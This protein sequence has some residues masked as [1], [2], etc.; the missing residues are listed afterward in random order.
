MTRKETNSY[1]HILKYTGVFGGV[2]GLSILMGLLR[3][4][5]VAV[6]LGPGGMG[7]VSLFNTVVNFVSQASTF[8]ISFS[9]VRHVS[10]LYDRG[11]TAALEHYVGVIRSWTLLVALFGV[12]LCIV[13]GPFLSDSTFAWG[14]HTLHFILLS[15]AVGMLA[16][17]GGE[18]AILKGVRRLRQLAL[19]QL[20]SIVATL[21]ISVPVFY[22]FC[23]AG[24]V[25][26]IVLTTLATMLVTLHFS[27]RLFPLKAV[28][29]RLLG[30]GM[31][32]VRLGVA[33]TAAGIMGS[34]AELLV[35]SFLNVRGDLDVV[36]LYNSAYMLCVTYAGMVFSAMETDYFPRLSAANHDPM[37]RN[38]IVNRQIEVSLLIVSPM[39]SALIVALP[40]VVPLL[41]SARFAPI[42]PM[43]QVMV[44]A[45]YLRAVTL[46]VS[47]IMLATGESKY[48]LL[49]EAFYDI[50]LVMLVTVLFNWMGL[51]GTGVA[52]L[53]LYV[54]EAAVLLAFAHAH[55]GTSLTPQ[56][57]RCV[58]LQLPL[59]LLAYLCTLTLS[60]LVYW[61]AGLAV[62]LASTGVSAAILRSKTSLWD[63]LKQKN[64]H[65]G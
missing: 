34:G 6:L 49:M 21:A 1:T 61:M 44:I 37:E 20:A 15:P 54:L 31:G 8:G 59:G 27:L 16:V 30:D 32:M 33:Y 7:L 45:M 47:Y 48:Y 39:L 10:E 50:L 62:V 2:Q 17:T 65:H 35:R 56:V 46:P 38:R 18:T 22:F 9:A 3:N 41:F 26:V 14:D 5:I 58:A 40:V 60:G 63:I 43:G 25:P 53:A 57:L 4:K 55:Y 11:D 12:L 29:A 19:I 24:I 52:L 13:L 36:G 28:G 42:V 51:L 64:Q 23:E